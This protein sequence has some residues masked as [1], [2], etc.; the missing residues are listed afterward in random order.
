MLTSA[1]LRQNMSLL[2]ADATKALFCAIIVYWLDNYCNA[3]LFGIPD[4]QLSKLQRLQNHAVRII[5]KTNKCDHI[6]LVLQDLHW[7]LVRNRV[8]HTILLLTFKSLSG[9]PPVFLGD[10][11]QPYQP[12]VNLQSMDMNYVEV[13]TV[14]IESHGERTF[15]AAAKRLEL[16]TVANI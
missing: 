7:L 3:V 12:V 4:C 11:L 9:L 6:I 8:I 13:P 1:R 5:V 10:L 15:S 2:S 16:F 14:C